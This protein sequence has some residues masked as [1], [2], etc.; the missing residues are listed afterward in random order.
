VK[1]GL[2]NK[3][4]LERLRFL[5]RV[6]EK[7]I[8]HLNYSAKKVFDQPFTYK[9]A[10]SLEKDA[11][12]AEQVEAFSSRF[13]RLQDTIGDKLL[14]AWL[15]VLGENP[16]IAIENLDK[17]EKIGVLSSVELWLELRQLRN[18][19]VHEYI[20]DLSVLADALQTSFENLEFIV[21]VGNAIVSDLEKRGLT[22]S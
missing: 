14:P 2:A 18:Q 7:E 4:K 15:D 3:A 5:R 16:K 11:E 21:G 6:V 10:V 12:L 1:L 20:E 17:A 9:R 19:M 22:V 8:V 13:C